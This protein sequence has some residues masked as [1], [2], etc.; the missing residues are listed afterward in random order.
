MLTLVSLCSPQ[1]YRL[2]DKLPSHAGTYGGIEIP[3]EVFQTS[4]MPF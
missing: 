3:Q 1:I 2:A 4:G